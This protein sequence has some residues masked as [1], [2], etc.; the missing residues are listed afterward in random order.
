LCNGAKKQ[1]PRRLYFSKV[2]KNGG[3]RCQEKKVKRC[4]N[5]KGRVSGGGPQ[6][7]HEL[8]ASGEALA[9][10]VQEKRRMS[11]ENRALP[12]GDSREEGE[13]LQIAINTG[14]KENDDRL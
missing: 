7:R 13:K 4:V 5:I 10:R 3:S 9:F 8:A 14:K 1:K 12:I 6:D 2:A 11:R